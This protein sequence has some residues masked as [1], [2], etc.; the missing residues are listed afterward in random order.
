MGVV[1]SSC[2]FEG[3]GTTRSQYIWFAAFQTACRYINGGHSNLEFEY[4]GDL[5]PNL[6]IFYDMN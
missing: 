2:F 6:K 4:L 3:K 1:M 5:K